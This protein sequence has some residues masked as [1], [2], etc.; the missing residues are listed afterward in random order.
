MFE[1]LRRSWLR[2]GGANRRAATARRTPVRARLECLESRCL[3]SLAPADSGYQPDMEPLRAG[4]FEEVAIAASP[5]SWVAAHVAKATS[6]SLETRYFDHFIPPIARGA[7]PLLPNGPAGN[8]ALEG[9]LPN[10]PSWG[11]QPDLPLPPYELPDSSEG[12]GFM[13]IGEPKQNQPG[14]FAEPAA[15]KVTRDVLTML[16]LLRYLPDSPDAEAAA[17]S[18]I[19][20]VNAQHQAPATISEERSMDLPEGGMV[21][22]VRE[23]VIVESA[24]AEPAPID[25]DSL[26][27]APP[28]MDSAHGKF[29]AFEVSTGEDSPPPAAPPAERGATNAPRPKP[30]METDLVADIASMM[31]QAPVEADSANGI[32]EEAVESIEGEA[33]SRVA[34]PAASDLKTSSS[35]NAAGA[36]LLAIAARATRVV[37][38]SGTGERK[39]QAA[40]TIRPANRR[41]PAS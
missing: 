40:P 37:R 15:D 39:D 12:G 38:G 19:P 18:E 4:D 28:R 3:L 11:L 14:I 36:I 13:D 16:A 10:A 6:A 9:G 22:L 24:R 7:L 23:A 1:L 26:L 34:P 27:G 29:Q 25:I 35:L 21:G 32:V 17:Q 8:G 41:D 31:S 30:T 20:T 5:N 33:P 2:L